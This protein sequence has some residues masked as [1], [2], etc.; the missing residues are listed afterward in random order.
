MIFV[1]LMIY[2]FLL[3]FC[4]SYFTNAGFSVVNLLLDI[5]I[6]FF[7]SEV[8]LK[9]WRLTMLCQVLAVK[10]IE[11]LNLSGTYDFMEIVS[12]ISKLHHPNMSELLG[13]CSE[14]GYKCLVYEYQWNGS[15]HGFLH[16]SDEYSKPLTWGT[17]VRIAL[18]T[19]RA[20]E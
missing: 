13:Y 3:S 17:R 12:D 19:A 20:V 7:L 10:K 5:C 16:L 9:C 6:Y 4:A 1:L 11:T 2:I 8:W 14:S 18:G 15:L